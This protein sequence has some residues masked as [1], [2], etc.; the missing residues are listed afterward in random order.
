MTADLPWPELLLVALDAAQRGLLQL[1]ASLGL[2]D[3]MHGQPAWPWPRRLALDV[4]AIDRAL[5]R[6]V[7]LALP[8]LLLLAALM[9]Y[10]AWRRRGRV[11]ALLLAGLLAGLWPWPDLTLLLGPARPTSFH[12]SPTAFAADSIVRGRQLYRQHCAACHG[13]DGTGNGPRPAGLVMWPP[14]LTGSLLWRRT[15]GDLLWALLH[16]VRDHRGRETM[17]GLAGRLDTA[18]AWAVIDFLHANAAGQSLRREGRWRHPLPLPDT[19]VVC[20]DGPTRPLRAWLP[21]RL[22]LVAVRSGEVLREDPRVV[23]IALTTGQPGVQAA[24][25]IEAAAA[26]EAFAL[27]AGATPEALAGT[28]FLADRQG[29]LRA[30]ATADQDGW[31][32]ADLVCRGDLPTGTAPAATG[33]LDGLIARMDAE[34]VRR[35]KAGVPH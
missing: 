13:A 9:L 28:R 16:G 15:D 10:A 26:W 21:Q 22:H 14:D 31:S 20:G 29:W 30:R 11:I 3:D 25:R 34:P 8:G 2:A 5:A 1:L 24:C 33:G 19:P 18:D 4:L 32:Q 23:T 7:A 27:F 12:V 17:P 6:R 35:I